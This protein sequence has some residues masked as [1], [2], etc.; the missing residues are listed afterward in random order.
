M[1]LPISLHLARQILWA[2][3]LNTSSP[4]SASDTRTQQLAK[5]KHSKAKLHYFGMFDSHADAVEYESQMLS[6]D[7]E[8]LPPF[9]RDVR[10]DLDDE[11]MLV[12]EMPEPPVRYWKW[13]TAQV[14][15]D[16]AG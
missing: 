7:D 5:R 12:E 11:D 13:L 1:I 8:D 4:A 15:D 14:E 6:V 9:A 16:D 3:S 10:D 2:A